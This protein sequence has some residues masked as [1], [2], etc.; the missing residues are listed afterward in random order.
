MRPPDQQTNEMRKRHGVG[1]PSTSRTTENVYAVEG[2]VLSQED[3]SGTT[4]QFLEYSEKLIF[5]DR[6]DVIMFSE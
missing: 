4:E 1:M 3:R 6:N 2:H 5:R